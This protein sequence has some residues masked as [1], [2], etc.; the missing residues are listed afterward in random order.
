MRSGNYHLPGGAYYEETVADIWFADEEH[1]QANGF[2][3]AD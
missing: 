3:R 2:H 1:A